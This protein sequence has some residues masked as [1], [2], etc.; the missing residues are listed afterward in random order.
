MPMTKVYLRSGSSPEHRRAISRAI[1]ASLIE[2]LGIPSDDLYHV[3]H[4]LGDD[5]LITV[6]VAFGLERR[7]QAVFIQ[8]YFGPRPAEVLNELYAAVVKRLGEQAGLQTRDIYINVVP[9]PSEY[10]W[11]DGRV[12]DPATGFD[13]RIAPDK[14]PTQN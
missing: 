1:H 14:V 7:H 6:P 2:V 5:Y 3:F 8:L 12:L 9:S 10:W 4:E 13:V 11:A